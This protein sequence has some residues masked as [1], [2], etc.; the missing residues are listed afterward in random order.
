MGTVGANKLCERCL[1]CDEDWVSKPH[2]SEVARV[3]VCI[4]RKPHF[5]NAGRCPQFEEVGNVDA[6]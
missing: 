4:Y 1:N 6:D 3:K 5:P 2:S